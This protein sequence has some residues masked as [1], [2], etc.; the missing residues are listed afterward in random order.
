MAQISKRVRAALF[1]RLSARFNTVLAAAAASY[2]VQPFTIDF[3][4]VPGSPNFFYGQLDPDDIE[5]SSTFKYPLM[6]LYTVTSAN[7]A[8]QKPAL[9]AGVV[10]VGLDVHLSWRQ[11]K[12]TIDFEAMGDLVEETMTTVMNDL[13]QQNW[14]SNVL[15]SGKMGLDRGPV[16]MGGENWRQQLRFSFL[17][18]VVA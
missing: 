10:R 11:G 7:Q 13:T 15:Y 14:G 17:F 2:G 3:N 5:E 8:A 1:A 18:D 12:A 6:T 4:S 16:R 9:F